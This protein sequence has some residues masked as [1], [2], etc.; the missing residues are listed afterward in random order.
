ME[1]P[2]RL[3]VLGNRRDRFLQHAMNF[4]FL[5]IGNGE[6]ALFYHPI[7]L[8]NYKGLASIIPVSPRFV[9]PGSYRRHLLELFHSSPFGP[10][11]HVYSG[12]KRT[13]GKLVRRTL[14]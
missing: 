10:G 2:S 3:L 1:F 9:A 6:K 13:L 11:R 4:A 5:D 7:T 14:L 12:L 8:P